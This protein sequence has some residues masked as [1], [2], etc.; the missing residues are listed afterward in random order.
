MINEAARALDQGIVRTAAEV[1]LAM[2]MGTGFPPF[3][4]GLLR[5]ADSMHP[6]G[7]LD[8]TRELETKHGARFEAADL[9]VE[10]ATSDRTF[11]E[12]FGT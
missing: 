4:G 2:I 11:Y 5:F 7:V 9:L 6:K 1:D 12:A 3:R 8:R 10:L